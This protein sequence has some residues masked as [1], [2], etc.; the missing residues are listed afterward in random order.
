MDLDAGT[1]LGSYEIVA[2]IGAGGMGTVYRALDTKLGREI[3]IKILPE[4]FSHDPD[5]AARFEREARLLASLNHP[6]IATLHG[7]EE[8]NGRKFLV[9]ELVEG[10]TLGERIARGALPIAELLPLFRQIAE[11]LEAAH[12]KGVVHRDLKPPNIKITPEGNIKVLDFGLAKAFRSEAAATDSGLS[13]SPTMTR[14]TA[15]GVILGTAPYMSPE[16]AKGRTVDRKIGI[17]STPQAGG[18]ETTLGS[19]GW[20]AR[21]SRKLSLKRPGTITRP[22]SLPMEARS[23]SRSAVRTKVFGST[24]S[25]G[26]R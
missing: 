1:R 14:G 20:I 25:R 23:A 9:M 11:A 18:W 17:W 8:F 6:H 21:A 15:T 13:E 4:E 5:R 22:T 12:E 3:A 19:C 10:E 26:P 24:T 2:F 7:L 16:Q